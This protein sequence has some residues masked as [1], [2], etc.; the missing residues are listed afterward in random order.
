MHA[1]FLEAGE[2]VDESTHINELLG[3]AANQPFP[4]PVVGADGRYRGTISKSALL[5]KLCD[6]R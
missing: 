3:R 2:A 6:A 4:L 1:A 5:H